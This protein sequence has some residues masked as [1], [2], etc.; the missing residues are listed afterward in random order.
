MAALLPLISFSL[1]FLLFSFSKK[2]YREGLLKAGVVWGLGAVVLTEVSSLF[3]L[4]VFPV[5]A[6]GWLLFCIVPVVPLWRSHQEYFSGLK[7]SDFGL[8]AG[9]LRS[10]FSQLSFLP[11]VFV[12]FVLLVVGITGLLSVLTPPVNYDSMSYHLPRVMHWIQDKNVAFYPTDFLPQLHEGPAAEY[13]I[14]QFQLLSGSDVLAGGVQWFAMVGSLVG[15]SLIAKLLGADTR[16]QALAVIF[17]ATLPM[18]IL[19]AS[20]TQTDYVNS[21]WLVCFV[22]FFLRWKVS[23]DKFLFFLLSVSLG[24]AILT[25]PVAYFVAFPFTL[26]LFVTKLKGSKLTLVY[27]LFSFGLFVILLNLPQYLRNISLYGSPVGP[28]EE[29]PLGNSYFYA[30]RDIGIQ[31]MI[32]QFLRNLSLHLDTPF[33]F[34]NNLTLSFIRFVHTIIGADINNPNTTWGKIPFVMLDRIGPNEDVTGNLVH[35]LLIFAA[36]VLFFT[37]KQ[38]RENLPV[39][40]YLLC[41]VG[42]ILLFCLVLIYQPWSSRLHLPFF[43]L[44]T[45]FLALTLANIRPQ[46][47]LSLVLVVLCLF[48]V[49]NLFLDTSKPFVGGSNI[50]TTSRIDSYFRKNPTI[51]ES[52]T[53]ATA[54]IKTQNCSSLGLMLNPNEYEYPIWKLLETPGQPPLII[55]NVNVPNVSGHLR[56]EDTVDAPCA[57]FSTRSPGDSVSIGGHAY[58]LIGTFQAVKVFKY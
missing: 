55:E 7:L 31:T 19:Q 10:R 17:C 47:L 29:L 45:P 2:D 37:Q 23:G 54:L 52:Y 35:T 33:G 24:L 25:K 38:L 58:K 44:F 40:W 26:Y 6:L 48:A 16:V 36:I 5:I 42:G 50:F 12:V 11:R 21:F 13:F 28:P 34:I 4:L 9:E 3:S 56:P 39:L 18:G 49:P 57:V 46:V 43:V 1:F 51:Q 22:Y 32:S 14:L 27:L 30:N 15:V 8:L 53:Q 20:S 41:L